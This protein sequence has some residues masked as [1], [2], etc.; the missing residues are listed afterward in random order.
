MTHRAR[1]DDAA[2]DVLFFCRW[3]DDAMPLAVHV[4]EPEI[5]DELQDEFAPRQPQEY[6]AAAERALGTW[7]RELE[8]LV[9]FH[10][11]DAREAARL[12]VWLLG[13]RAPFGRPDAQVLGATPE[14]RRCRVRGEDPDADRLRVDFAV[15]SVTLYVADTFGLL[16]PDLV[17][18]T[19]LHEIG[20]ALGMLGHSPIPADLMRAPASDRALASDEHRIAVPS[21]SAQDVNSFV[22]LYRLPNGT[23]YGRVAPDGVAPRASARPGPPQL[24]LG[25]YVDARL[26][27]ELRTPKGWLRVPT[28]RG[29]VAVDGVT[30]E[31]SPTFQIVVQRYPTI[32]AYLERYGPYY[33]QRGSIS[34]RRW[35]EVD[36]HRALEVSIRDFAGRFVEDVTLVEVGD[37]R[38]FV[39]TAECPAD[40]LEDYRPWFRAALDSLEIVEF[41]GRRA[42]E[43]P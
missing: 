39:V 33:R 16:P 7:E 31:P 29:V 10:L 25:P 2:G 35:G 4:A 3:S 1:R 27:F 38:L 36:G 9:R 20:H 11:V 13:Q 43:A 6:R 34:E 42:R 14:A 24:S 26:G 32:E 17:E 23:I 37:G 41:G 40:A 21:L 8:G 18:W 15:R 5:P 22:S 30:W 19:A 12:V 28:A